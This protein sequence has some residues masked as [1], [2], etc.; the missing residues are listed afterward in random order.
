MIVLEP[1]TMGLRECLS[2]APLVIDF[3]IKIKYV[4]KNEWSVVYVLHH[5]VPNV[6]YPSAGNVFFVGSR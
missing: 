6:T 4:T 3:R 1:I 5:V 2:R